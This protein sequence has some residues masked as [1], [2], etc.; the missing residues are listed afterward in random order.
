M[1]FAGGRPGIFTVLS[2]LKKDIQ[3]RIGNVEWLAYL[4]ILTQTDTDWKTLTMTPENNF[5][6]TNVEYFDRSGLNHKTRLFRVISNPSNPTG[7]ARAGGE[8]E[9]LMQMAE[10]PGNGILLDEA[11]EMYHTPSVSGLKY[12]RDLDN[13]NV[14]LSGA[15]TKGLQ[16]PGIR[17]GWM[18]ASKKTS[19]RCPTSAPSAWAGR[20][21]PISLT[22]SNCSS[23]S[24]SRVSATTSA[25]SSYK[26]PYVRHRNRRSELKPGP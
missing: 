10:L 22:P 14:F 5:H 16:C 23:R 13:S 1:I 6:P 2:F 20:R 24:G 3:V 15:C 12:V 7:H 8:L 21:I 18:I 17:I 25:D 11:Y 9:E 19:R 26:G 4:D